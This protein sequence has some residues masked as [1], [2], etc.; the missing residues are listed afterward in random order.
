MGG[1]TGAISA[2]NSPRL[3]GSRYNVAE[4]GDGLVLPLTGQWTGLGDTSISKCLGTVDN[5]L[6]VVAGRERQQVVGLDLD[7]GESDG[8][9]GP[10][11]IET[12]ALLL[13]NRAVVSSNTGIQAYD[14][15]NKQTSWSYAHGSDVVRILG[16]VGDR[17]LIST[18]TVE[19]DSISNGELRFLRR[20]TSVEQLSTTWT[21]WAGQLPD[22]T[23]V[24]VDGSATVRD[25]QIQ[26]TGGRLIRFDLT[27]GNREWE[28]YDA[29]VTTGAVLSEGIFGL[30]GQTLTLFDTDSGKQRRRTELSEPIDAFGFDQNT[31]YLL[32][33]D[34]TVV[35]LR[36]SDWSTVWRET[37]DEE[38]ISLATTSGTVFLGGKTQLTALT[39]ETGETA[40]Q[41]PLEEGST[42]DLRISDGR[43]FLS[44]SAGVRTFIDRRIEVAKAIQAAGDE[45]SIVERIGAPIEEMTGEERLLRRARE[46][47]EAGQY[48]RAMTL[49]EEAKQR[50]TF[51]AGGTG[52]LGMGGVYTVLRGRSGLATRGPR[53]RLQALDDRYPLETGALAGEAPTETRDALETELEE[54]EA[55][56][57]ILRIRSPDQELSPGLR[58]AIDDLI[59]LHERLETVSQRLADLPEDDEF[60]VLWSQALSD[61][62][63]RVDPEIE[64]FVQRFEAVVSRYR[65]ALSLMNGFEGDAE[66]R[67]LIADILET[68][69]KHTAPDV[70]HSEAGLSF[71]DG[72]L[73]AGAALVSQSEAGSRYDMNALIG[74]LRTVAAET[75]PSGTQAGATDSCREVSAVVDA[76]TRIE[77]RVAEASRE[78]ASQLD[79]GH[80]RRR[81]QEA[82]DSVDAAAATRMA[83][84]I[85]DVITRTWRPETLSALPVEQLV[86]ATCAVLTDQGYDISRIHEHSSEVCFVTGY[87][88]TDRFVAVIT[89]NTAVDIGSILEETTVEFLVLVGA[90]AEQEL[91]VADAFVP[92]SE[93]E[94]FTYADLADALNSSKLTPTLC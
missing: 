4:A 84:T 94:Q 6:Y 80:V 31:L 33:Q 37:F 46:A 15:P 38:I 67:M 40:Q 18:G 76:I 12:A 65:R 58:D 41:I 86:E 30:G 79:I 2:L 23:V 16:A 52:L 71:V 82:I 22:D 51:A 17:V 89:H 69:R 64:P 45:S 35:A 36:R 68:V 87:R 27:T 49:V 32:T 53:K 93:T 77:E 10:E 24:Y 75:G 26:P 66:L 11:S 34:S 19:G 21:P 83:A 57:G 90:A 13:D 88:G 44:S 42:T 43:I 59:E 63:D 20:G 14:L 29:G 74:H 55:D 81:L 50:Q 1:I 91:N 28:T 9:V 8:A 85:D 92:S 61:R 39:S 60:R 48:D 7:S 3:G 73:N 78:N 72:L 62:F 47:H 5:T 25:N 70:N 56:R 54:M